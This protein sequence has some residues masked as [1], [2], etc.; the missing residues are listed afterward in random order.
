[1]NVHGWN[2]APNKNP[3]YWVQ[4]LQRYLNQVSQFKPAVPIIYYRSFP[5]RVGPV[6]SV[7]HAESEQ[8]QCCAKHL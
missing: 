6:G 5:H 1:M 8:E 3:D 7:K 4:Y 2:T